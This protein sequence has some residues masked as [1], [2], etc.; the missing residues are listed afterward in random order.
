V[1]TDL[2]KQAGGRNNGG[3]E[4]DRNDGRLGGGKLPENRAGLLQSKT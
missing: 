2:G 4:A 1:L 3:R